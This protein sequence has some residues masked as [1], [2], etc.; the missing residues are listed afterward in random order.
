MGIQGTGTGQGL[1]PTLNDLR[2]GYPRGI[3]SSA[4]KV[5]ETTVP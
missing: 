2:L 3:I 1:V 4:R 5:A